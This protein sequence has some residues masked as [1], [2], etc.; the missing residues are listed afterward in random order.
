MNLGQDSRGIR[1]RNDQLDFIENSAPL[2][3]PGNILPA[4]VEQLL[5]QLPFWWDFGHKCRLNSLPS[6]RSARTTLFGSPRP[7]GPRGGG[8]LLPEQ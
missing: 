2:R 5:G 6:L 4:G 8:F 1:L 3:N 7:W